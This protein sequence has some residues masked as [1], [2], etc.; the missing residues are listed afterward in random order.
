MI[1]IWTIAKKGCQRYILT[2]ESNGDIFAF[3]YWEGLIFD[4]EGVT[5]RLWDF[6]FVPMLEFKIQLSWLKRQ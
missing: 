2:Y 4:I 1:P 3:E 5:V 6:E